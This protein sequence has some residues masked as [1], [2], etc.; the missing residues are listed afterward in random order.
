MREI[1]KYNS[2]GVL[3]NKK[4]KKTFCKYK[5]GTWHL[6]ER[7]VDYRHLLLNT[8]LASYLE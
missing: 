8:V 2:D 1:K 4:N 5:N 3:Q 7:W 6:T